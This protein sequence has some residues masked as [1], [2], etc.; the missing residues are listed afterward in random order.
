MILHGLIAEAV[1]KD[2]SRKLVLEEASKSDASDQCENE[3]AALNKPF[4]SS[5]YV[6][7]HL[8]VY[9]NSDFED[10]NSDIANLLKCNTGK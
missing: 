9:D 6:E 10:V 8:S 3:L 7:Q 4:D 2:I 1:K 5:D